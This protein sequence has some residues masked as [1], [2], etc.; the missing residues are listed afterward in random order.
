MNKRGLTET[1]EHSPLPL[2]KQEKD[3]SS[4]TALFKIRTSRIAAAVRDANTNNRMPR[5]N[6][7][8]IKADHGASSFTNTQHDQSMIDRTFSIKPAMQM[9]EPLR[10][11][12]KPVAKKLMDHSTMIS[13]FF[14]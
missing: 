5:I 4:P 12:S 8:A 2:N 14:G 9:L 13:A 10:M 7:G 1:F 3:H 11:N 6:M